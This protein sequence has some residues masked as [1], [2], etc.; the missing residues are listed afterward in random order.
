MLII[1]FGIPGVGK[2]FIGKLLAEQYGY[3]FYEADVDL[4]PPMVDAVHT[5]AMFT[6]EMRDAFFTTVIDRI[7][8]FKEKYQN[9]VVAQAM[10]K[11]KNRLQILKQFPQARFI[12]VDASSDV[13]DKRLSV[14]ADWVSFSYAEKVRKIFDSPKIPHLLLENNHGVH[15]LKQ[16]LT[17][18]MKYM[19][20]TSDNLISIKPTH[21]SY[22]VVEIAG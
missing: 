10:A 1:L 17:L 19:E 6:D 22:E 7:A 8:T 9:V 18:K 21:K 3:H 16:Q 13:I 11:E 20:S 4:T 2:S 15:Q 14:R 12:W 5:G